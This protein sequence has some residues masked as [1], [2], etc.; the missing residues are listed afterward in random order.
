MIGAIIGDIAG[1]RF[2]FDN[3]R[4]KDFVM[5]HEKCKVTDD[6]IM[7]L[8]VAKAIM[9]T[10]KELGS[11]FKIEDLGMKRLSEQAVRFMQEIGR[12]Y[13][14]CGYGGMFG[15]WVF[16]PHPEP[17]CSFGNGAAMRVIRRRDL[18]DT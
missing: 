16:N 12:K 11:L 5:F 10:K 1:S 17:Y 9:E 7:T 14:D 18:R 15:N 3:H 13:P 2:E 6:T 4:S 8:A